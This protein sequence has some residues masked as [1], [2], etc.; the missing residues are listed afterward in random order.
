MKNT[1]ALVAL[2]SVSAGAATAGD[3]AWNAYSEYAIEAETFEFGIGGDYVI[4][5]FTLSGEM[6]LTKPN[7]IDLD[8]ERVSVG[9]A[10]AATSKLNIYSVVDFDSDLSYSEATIGAAVNF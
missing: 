4:D 1:L 2:L 5:Q 10:Y 6:V 9:V 8:I 3:F 7:N